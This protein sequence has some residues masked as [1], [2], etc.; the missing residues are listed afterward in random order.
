MCNLIKIFLTLLIG[1]PCTV[2]AQPQPEPKIP[3]VLG[4][5]LSYKFELYNAGTG[6][7]RYKLEARVFFACD[8]DYVPDQI[9]FYAYKRGD[10]SHPIYR[11][12]R[13]VLDRTTTVTPANYDPCIDVFPNSCFKVAYYYAYM[14]IPAYHEGVEV[15]F[16]SESRDNKIIN[17]TKFQTSGFWANIPS[18]FDD[19]SAP[20]N[21]SPQFTGNEAVYACANSPFDFNA[22]ATDPDQDSLSY[23][24][25]PGY[26]KATPPG[27]L[28]YAN[29]FSGTDPMGP[30]IAIDPKTG[31]LSGRTPGP[32]NYSVT[33]FVN[34]YRNGRLICTNSKE[35]MFTIGNCTIARAELP[36][37][38]L[39]C[40]DLTHQ[41]E[42][43]VKSPLIKS[44]RWDFG[45]PGSLSDTSTREHPIF[46]YPDTGIYHARLII[47]EGL[48]CDDTAFTKVYAYPKVN[49]DYTLSDSCLFP[50]STAF[51]QDKSSTSIG[52]LVKWD[53]ELGLPGP[54]GVVKS[55]EQNPKLSYTVA[56]TFDI[57]LVVYSDLGC[58]DTA[59]RKLIVYSKD[60]LK[61]GNDTTICIG[62]SVQLFS[63]GPG[64]IAWTPAYR[65]LNPNSFTP[66]AFPDQLTTYNATLTLFPGC[67]IN[68]SL[69][70]DAKRFIQ[71]E[72]GPDTLIC[73][74]D[75]IQFHPQSDALTFRWSP[76][77]TIDNP[78]S[79]NARTWPVAA[80]T[81]YHVVANTGSC[82]AEDSI[83][84]FTAPYP[85]ASVGPDL[86]VCYGES[87]QLQA[88]GGVRYLWTPSEGL[89]DV[90]SAT[91]FARPSKTTTYTVSV[92]G[93]NGCPK[94]SLRQVTVTALPKVVAFAGYDTSVIAGQPLQL[95]ASGASHFLWSPPLG[96]NDPAIANPI[97][98][99]QQDMIYRVKASTDE[100]C[101]AEDD[102]RVKVFRTGPE[103]FVPNAFTPNGDGRNDVIRPTPVGIRQFDYFRV[104]NR[105]GQLIFTT[106]IPTNGWD[107]L[108]GGNKALGGTYVWEARGI[109][110]TGKAILKRGSFI[111]IR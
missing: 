45:V 59:F 71:V 3:L 111:L 16:F 98:T 37:K 104:Y 78:A 40:R 94:P 23:Y 65:L 96:L 73:R 27:Y 10:Y 31:R 46:T 90:S 47:N 32:G 9:N 107:G 48:G 24:L 85:L 38:T 4:G 83:T 35:F 101:F 64:T 79:K 81:R 17:L 54:F 100:G 11:T 30:G 50:G 29:G 57:R 109:D 19:T 8:V 93:N 43:L 1:F 80:S 15:Y 105:W 44:W 60:F 95:Q 58:T 56:D 18:D 74:G 42:N 2:Y 99:V 72:A 14:I 87:V 92:Y 66:I 68:K 108:M 88:T 36:E 97:A 82:V 70:V 75:T 28:R 86:P 7:I 41:F 53:W 49:A 76:V 62:D 61:L 20:R 69:R 103:I 67:V 13:I 34:E 52:K 55:S 25:N 89:S 51:F 33:V 39:V 91:P 22:G 84:V 63:S 77:G 12:T 106:R 26:I 21:S 102:I 5:N 110:Y 6:N